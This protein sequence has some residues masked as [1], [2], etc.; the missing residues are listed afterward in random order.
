GS[1]GTSRGRGWDQGR[2]RGQTPRRGRGSGTGSRG[3]A[4]ERRRP[5]RG[6]HAG[7]ARVGRGTRS[8]EEGGLRFGYGNIHGGSGLDR[9]RRSRLG[10]ASASSAVDPEPTASAGREEALETAL[11]EVE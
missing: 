4:I 6:A 9:P 10:R 11:E 5:A 7:D 3:G 2:R 1:P 8:V